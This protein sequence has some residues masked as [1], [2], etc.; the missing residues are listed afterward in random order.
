M[1][2][3]LHGAFLLKEEPW[4][5]E[6]AAYFKR[7]SEEGMPSY[8]GWEENGSAR[9]RKIQYLYLVSRFVVLA[10]RANRSDLIPKG[11]VD[12]LGE[13]V[14]DIWNRGKMIAWQGGSFNNMRDCLQWKLDTM[15]TAKS[16]F[17]AIVDEERFTQAI[18][19]DLKTYELLA[20]KKV[21]GSKAIDEVLEYALMTYKQR[22][23]YTDGDAWVFQPG[24]WVDHPD[25]AYSA[26]NA[27]SEGMRPSARFNIS[28]DSSHSHRTP[29]WLTSLSDAY[30]PGSAN[31]EYY[32]KLRSGLAKQFLTKVLV[33]PKDDFSGIRLANYLDGSN[34][35][36]RWEYKNLGG[37][38]R[39]YQPYGLSF[40][41]MI[42]W[43]SF[44]NNDEVRKAYAEQAKTF[45]LK[46]RE[47]MTYYAEQTDDEKVAL[48]ADPA[49]RLTQRTQWQVS[50]S[51]AS[52]I[53]LD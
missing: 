24:V 38:N 27:V 4:I 43:W 16:Y 12:F 3:P 50:T 5:G 42:G 23:S 30:K 47:L 9:Q 33:W 17:R 40:V 11:M 36:Y 1:L 15:S 13:A 19:G 31:Y 20:D 7:F 39:G 35:I 45:P 2:V 25:Y 52:K 48:L 44:L 49:K 28:E 22:V 6:L 10:T 21:K 8:T 18:A 41:F 51:I 14:D 34:G 53:Q 32:R 46:D 26:V 37:A 29:L